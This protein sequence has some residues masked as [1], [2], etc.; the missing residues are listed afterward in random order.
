MRVLLKLT[1][2]FLSPVAFAGGSNIDQQ[3]GSDQAPLILDDGLERKAAVATGDANDEKVGS[4]D[5][6]VGLSEKNPTAFI[7][8]VRQNLKSLDL[9]AMAK[10]SFPTVVTKANGEL[11]A[12]FEPFLK[13]SVMR[14]KWEKIASALKEI[15]DASKSKSSRISADP[16]NVY[17]ELW[18]VAVHRKEIT[19]DTVRAVVDSG[20]L[21]IPKTGIV[22]GLDFTRLS[23]H[24]A[25]QFQELHLWHRAELKIRENEILQAL[26]RFVG[27]VRPSPVG[28]IVG[29]PKIPEFKVS[30]A[31]NYIRYIHE[32][33][34][35]GADIRPAVFTSTPWVPNPGQVKDE[36]RQKFLLVAQSDSVLE[37]WKEMQN[38]FV[39]ILNAR[40]QR[41]HRELFI[42]DD[43]VEAFFMLVLINSDTIMR[44]GIEAMLLQD[45][46]SIPFAGLEDSPQP[47][48][49]EIQDR[50]ALLFRYHARELKFR[51][52]DLKRQLA[53]ELLARP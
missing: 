29:G 44:D 35:Q 24:M 53:A 48:S 27:V 13:A 45:G 46:I 10:S 8:L 7:N 26:G 31:A 51:E 11:P 2:V 17:I 20:K 19:W 38:I 37:N 34:R 23:P 1:L 49:K 6:L 3:I 40:D 28:P 33:Q 18:E 47:V 52:K 5:C 30:K 50:M 43:P 25:L 15:A 9:E 22:K 12:A 16:E 14:K 36:L 41:D 21:I 4:D 39:E 42:S 32:A